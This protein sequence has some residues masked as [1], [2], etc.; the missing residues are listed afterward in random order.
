MQLDFD[1]RKPQG[2]KLYFPKD[3]FNNAPKKTLK[4]L[5][6]LF[7]FSDKLTWSKEKDFVLFDL[8]FTR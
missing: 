1:L 5:S 6:D 7:F 3:I 4:H 8:Q 2:A